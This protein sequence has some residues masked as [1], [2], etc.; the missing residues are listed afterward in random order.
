MNEIVRDAVDVPGDRDRV[1]QSQRDHQPERRPRK[2][3]KEQEKVGAVENSQGDGNNIQPGMGEEFRVGG[4]SFNSDEIC[5][6]V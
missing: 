4:D 6:H 3:V 5:F 1:E 2:K